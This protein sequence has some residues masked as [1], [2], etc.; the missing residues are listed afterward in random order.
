MPNEAFPQ[1]LPLGRYREYLLL[2]ARVQLSPRLQGKIDPSDVVQETLLKAH[3]AQG[4]FKGTSED[5]LRSWLRRILANT[6]IDAARR[7]GKD[8]GLEVSLDTLEQSSAR[9]EALLAGDPSSSPSQRS[10]NEEHLVRLSAA[11]N[12]LPEDQRSAV[13]LHHFHEYTVQAIAEEMG[14]TKESV[15]GL[16]RRG[17]RRL[18]QLLEEPM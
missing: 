18:R 2:L 7:Y 17:M 4:E 6:T 10:I 13:E 16:L 9:L 5:E 11:L 14:R 3:K 1:D 12:Q 15:G 8:V